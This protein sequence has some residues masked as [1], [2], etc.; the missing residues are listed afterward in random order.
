M[1][2]AHLVVAA[3]ALAASAPAQADAVHRRHV[4][5]HA[6]RAVT[7]D[8]APVPVRVPAAGA[9]LAAPS[10]DPVG[11][12]IDR[13]SSGIARSNAASRAV[14][15]NAFGPILRLLYPPGQSGEL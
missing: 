12:D 7:P 13:I 5:S 4:G 2:K 11:S 1:R 6:R 9:G 3:L 10:R 15:T 8:F 14:T